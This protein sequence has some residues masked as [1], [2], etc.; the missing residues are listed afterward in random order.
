M[1][2]SSAD[3]RFKVRGF[4]PLNPRTYIEGKWDAIDPQSAPPLLLL[5][6]D[7]GVLRHARPLPVLG[8][9]H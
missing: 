5:R 6:I 8:F 4:S 2:A 7:P 3:L 9:L 1:R